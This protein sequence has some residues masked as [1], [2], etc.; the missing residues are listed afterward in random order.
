MTKTLVI[1]PDL[2]AD[3][4]IIARG[5]KSFV[6]VG[7]A[8]LRIREQRKYREREYATF[9]D[10]CKGHWGFV[11]SQ[12][13]NLIRS[14]QAVEIAQ[15]V[16]IETVPANSYQARELAAA[17]DPAEVW[18]EVVEEHE[19]QDITAAVIR[20]HVERR[21]D[22]VE[23]VPIVAETAADSADEAGFRN[24]VRH[25]AQRLSFDRMVEILGEE[26]S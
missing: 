4:A 7:Q 3:E 14:A 19:P 25:Y 16:S 5:M 9:A 10:Y 11:D 13:R 1:S 17:S 8:L 22:T 15:T 26:R 20:E 23:A 2:R 24:V 6:D 21:R 18:A 12:A